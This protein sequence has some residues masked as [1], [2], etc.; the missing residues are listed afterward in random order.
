MPKLDFFRFPIA[1]FAPFFKERVAFSATRPDGVRA[2][3]IPANVSA[4]GYDDVFEDSGA[5]SSRIRRA[6]IVVR[7][8]DWRAVV[9]SDPQPGDRFTVFASPRV[10]YAAAEVTPLA[11]DMWTIEAREVSDG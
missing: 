4:G 10:T 1:A 7:D 8:A 3:T 9:S 2:G 5:T 11:A 6:T